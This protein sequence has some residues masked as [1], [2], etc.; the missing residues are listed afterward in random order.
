MPS[1]R[2]DGDEPGVLSARERKKLRLAD[3][4]TIAVQPVASGS[5]E[6]QGNQQ[7]NDINPIAG[8]SKAIVNLDSTF[9]TLPPHHKTDQLIATSNARFASY[10]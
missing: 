10:D 2:K 6:K 1:K 7:K 8:P 4:R 5:S 3:A 9:V